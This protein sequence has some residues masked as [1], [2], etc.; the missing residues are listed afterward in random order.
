MTSIFYGFLT[1]FALSYFHYI[2]DCFCSW[3]SENQIKKPDLRSIFSGF[4]PSFVLAHFC[5]HV[6]AA[7]PVPLLPFIAKEFGLDNTHTGLVITAFS[8]A[9]GI[10][11]LPGGFLADRI[12][13]RKMITISICGIGL[14]GLLVGLSH[15]YIVMLIFLVFLGISGGGYH[16]SAPPLLAASVPPQIRGKAFGF[17]LIGGNAAFFLAPLMAAGIA[18]VWGWRG[19]FISLAIPTIIFGIVFYFLISKTLVKKVESAVPEKPPAP[20]IEDVPHPKGWV[21]EL[22]LFIALSAIV[23]SLCSS[24]GSFISV[25]SVNYLGTSYSTAAILVAVS[26]SSGLWVSP[27][28]GHMADRIGYIPTMLIS[29]I[30]A[31]PSIYLMTITPYGAGFIVVL[32]FW[33]ALNSIRLP[34]TE[35]YIMSRSS[36]KMRSTIFGIFYACAN[37]GTGILAPLLGYLFDRVGYAMGFDIIAFITL[38]VTILCGIF[39]WRSHTRMKLAASQLSNSI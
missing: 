20:S 38:V 23:S 1:N 24:T 26:M 29:C 10:S 13:P 27:F 14:S 2:L 33:G 34:A 6:V 3:S 19:T 15:S 30:A 8:L 35:S 5:N 11:Q 36:P 21:R 4:R 37:H 39:L 12:G 28:G 22:V 18:V 31:V 32:L 25:F 9:S 16:P 17:H 7:L